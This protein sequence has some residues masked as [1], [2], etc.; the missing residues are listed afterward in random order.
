MAIQLYQ[1]LVPLWRTRLPPD[2]P[3]LTWNAAHEAWVRALAGDRFTTEQILTDVSD[4]LP[5]S[6]GDA[7]PYARA[8][9]LALADTLDA[10]GAAVEAAALRKQVATATRGLF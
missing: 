3:R 9:R 2:D 5:R 10:R 1:S 7:H 6:L 4:W 8:V